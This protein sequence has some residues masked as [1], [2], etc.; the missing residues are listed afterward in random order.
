MGSSSASAVMISITEEREVE[1]DEDAAMHLDTY[2]SPAVSDT[3]GDISSLSDESETDSQTVY[4]VRLEQSDAPSLMTLDMTLADTDT[5]MS[6]DIGGDLPGLPASVKDEWQPSADGEDAD[7]GWYH[8]M[9]SARITVNETDGWGTEYDIYAAT[10]DAAE[11]EHI[12][13]VADERTAA[14]TAMTHLKALTR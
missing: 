11:P 5:G 2:D 1:I 7:Y 14:L 13:T 4:G 9:T 3:H 12:V 10:P 8:P 6:V